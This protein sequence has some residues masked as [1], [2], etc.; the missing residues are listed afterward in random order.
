MKSFAKILLLILTVI[1]LVIWPSQ[2]VLASTSYQVIYNSVANPKTGNSDYTT[3]MGNMGNSEDT[4]ESYTYELI[5]V[6]GT[7]SNL[8]VK[9]TT[10]AGG[11]GS[12][13]S[14][15]LTF[16][17][18]GVSQALSTTILDDNDTGVDAVN[19]VAVVAGNSV[20]IIITPANTPNAETIIYYSVTFTPTVV[21][22]SL[23]MSSTGGF[24]IG[25]VDTNYLALN[26]GSVTSTT[27]SNTSN[28][29]PTA[30]TISDMYLLLSAA[31]GAGKTRVFTLYKNGAPTT[32][33]A[34]IS[35]AAATTGNDITHS[36]AVVAGDTVSLESDPNGTPSSSQL[37][38]GFKFTATQTNESLVLG[39][40]YI[41]GTTVPT[42]VG[43]YAALIPNEQL[44]S[45]AIAAEA[46]YQSL[47]N[48]SLL[49]KM[50]V[51]TSN[52]AGAGNDW[53]FTVNVNGVNSSLTCS[54][55]DA[56]NS[57]NDTA[58]SATVADGDLISLQIIPTSNPTA[59]SYVKFSMVSYVASGFA[60][61]T[62]SDAQLVTQTTARW[63]GDITD[64]GDANASLR[65]FVWDTGT[66]GDPG[67]T[68]PAATAYS[69]SSSEA[70]SF[71]VAQF[72]YDASGLTDGTVYY[73]RAWAYNIVGYAYGNEVIAETYGLVLWYQPSTIVSGTTL[74]DRAGTA[75][76]GTIT[77]GSADLTASLTS[78][79]P[80]PT[81]TPNPTPAPFPTPTT[82][83]PTG[84]LPTPTPTSGFHIT[85]TPVDFPGK[86][87]IDDIAGNTPVQVPWMLLTGFLI[88]V[89]SLT[90]SWI[91]KRFGS[92]NVL[93]KAGV[94]IGLMG[95]FIGLEI[96]DFYMVLVF[97]LLAVAIAMASRQP[98]WNQ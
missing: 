88:L 71:G 21:G 24:N 65:G 4:N 6:A 12:G 92:G 2:P 5:S 25:N 30:G 70:G 8:R 60:T 84:F 80:P 32:I 34:T 19:T 33:T 78:F 42:A 26:D 85:P 10:D 7:F 67:N 39:S 35:G 29:M 50:Y 45:G 52:T 77:F 23:V 9:L 97:G 38:F 48:A 90:T 69:D 82:P 93:I 1:G 41:G 55:A 51:W 3:V 27:E 86:D 74:P 46:T 28:I 95:I 76:D 31:P 62:T 64:T 11:A 47:G 98:T 89:A 61:V 59:G 96:Y 83:T 20:S 56:N 87:I 94:I 18:G 40:G 22:Q 68:A 44:S 14:W 57:A 54:I 16:R 79:V 91:M 58:H 17:K 81:P 72:N 36:V 49:G 37:R 53:A 43:T 75:Q 15:T 63:I 73:I 13:K 66:H